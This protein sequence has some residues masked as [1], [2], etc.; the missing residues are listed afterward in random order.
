MYLGRNLKYLRERND[1]MQSEIMDRL[2]I[3]ASTWGMYENDKSQPNLK[4]LIYISK[5]FGVRESDLLH[6]DL[7][8]NVH[9]IGKKEN[10][11]N[12][13]NVHPSTKKQPKRGYESSD[14]SSFKAGAKKNT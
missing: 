13:K 14:E 5:Y 4:V 9:L 10:A 2:G 7:R 12:N 1:W 8:Q 11:E 6:E 3:K